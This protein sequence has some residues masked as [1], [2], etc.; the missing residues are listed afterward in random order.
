MVPGRRWNDVS[1]DEPL[2]VAENGEA[3]DR[4]VDG[5]L[6]AADDQS[7][8]MCLLTNPESNDEV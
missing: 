2:D 8:G 1:E 4:A 6:R 5:A 7:N 3:E